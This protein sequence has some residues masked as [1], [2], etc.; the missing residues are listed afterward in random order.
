MGK[1]KTYFVTGLIVLLPIGATVYI[2]GWLFRFADSFTASIV[3]LLLGKKIPG[4]GLLLTLGI[5]M[6]VGFLATNILGRSIINFSHQLL[7]RI[8]VVNS[9]Y[10]TVKQIVDA[11]WQKDKHAFQ[12]VVIIEYPRQGL[13]GLGFVTGVSEGEV[14]AKTRER[15]LNVFVPTTPNPTSGWL[16]LVPEKDVI[17]LEMSVE[18]GIKLIISGG[19]LTPEYKNSSQGQQD[20]FKTFNEGRAAHDKKE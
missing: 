8:P 9:I 1:L 19:V 18:E 3:T 17:P 11:F 4:L 15:V 7:S 12:R 6:L 5:I 13:Y 10:I 16:L 2:L 20:M 14:Q